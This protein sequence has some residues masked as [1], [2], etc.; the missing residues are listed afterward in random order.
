MAM[1]TDKGILVSEELRIWLLMNNVII[2]VIDVV[3]HTC[4]EAI[5]ELF[6]LR[7]IFNLNVQ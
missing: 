2:S 5:L 6:L 3:E 7:F 4:T 1:R